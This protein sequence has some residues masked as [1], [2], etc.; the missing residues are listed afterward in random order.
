MSQGM[1]WTCRRRDGRTEGNWNRQEG[2]EDGRDQAM[3]MH[4]S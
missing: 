3:S 1:A 4:L 2:Q